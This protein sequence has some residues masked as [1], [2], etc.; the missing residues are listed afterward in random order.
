MLKEK[1]LDNVVIC[2]QILKT[3]FDIHSAK[4]DQ[5]S[6]SCCDLLSDFKNDL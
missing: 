6:R 4:H 5:H 1:Y 3:I 2:F